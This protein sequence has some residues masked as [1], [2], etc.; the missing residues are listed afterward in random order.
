MTPWWSGPPCRAACASIV[1]R[2]LSLW[3][4]DNAASFPVDILE[5]RNGGLRRTFSGV[6][7]ENDQGVEPGLKGRGSFLKRSSHWTVRSTGLYSIAIRKEGVHDPRTERAQ[8]VDSQ[9]TTHTTTQNASSKHNRPTNASDA[10]PLHVH[11]HAHMKA[12]QYSY[13]PPLQPAAQQV[14]ARWL[15]ACL[16]RCRNRGSPSQ[17]CALRACVCAVGGLVDRRW[18]YKHT[19]RANLECFWGRSFRLA[20]PVRRWDGQHVVA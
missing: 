6:Q 9:T 18:R 3:L 4:A 10:A 16:W 13:S 5:I 2:C 14:G 1:R 8:P 17:R 15:R 19:G 20:R 11:V 12:L 7:F